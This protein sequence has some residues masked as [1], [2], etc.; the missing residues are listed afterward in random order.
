MTPWRC[1]GCNEPQLALAGAAAPADGLCHECRGKQRPAVGQLLVE[2]GVPP[3]FR[4]H[5][6]R[7][8][9]V[10]HF[11]RPWTLDWPRPGVHWL[12]LWGPTGTGK[13]SAATIL[14]AEHL[15][16][17]RR[18]LWIDGASL[19]AEL[20]REMDSGGE[21]ALLPRL[22]RTALLVL[23]EPFGGY[24]TDYVASQMLA[25]I[26]ARDQRELLTI[27][28]SQ[29][30]PEVLMARAAATRPDGEPLYPTGSLGAAVSRVLGG[31]VVRVDGEDARLAVAEGGEL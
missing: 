26:R 28:T 6:T 16:A 31:L 30:D 22:S 8:A 14:L 17:G 10:R 4:R 21:R 9:W 1:S 25:L 20:G 5:A 13:T 15:Q 29:L 11:G 3:K 23:D 19:V 24:V 2:A 27:V 12:C 7:R 18:G